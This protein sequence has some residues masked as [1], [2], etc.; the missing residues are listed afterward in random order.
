MG[1]P[2]KKG[3]TVIQTRVVAF[4]GRDLIRRVLL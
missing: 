1:G 2:N 3:T 4:G